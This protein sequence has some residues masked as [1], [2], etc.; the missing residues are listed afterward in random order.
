MVDAYNY[1][2]EIE[3]QR[4]D[5]RIGFVLAYLL[6]KPGQDIK[7]GDFVPIWKKPEENKTVEDTE[8]LKHRFRGQV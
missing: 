6:A 3:D 2:V 5:A 1:K 4:I 7:P 8:P